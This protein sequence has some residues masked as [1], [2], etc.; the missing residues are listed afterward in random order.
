MRRRLAE[1]ERL[2]VLPAGRVTLRPLEAS[3]AEELYQVFSDPV[4][5]RYWSSP[6]HGSIQ[7]TREMIASIGDGFEARTIFQWGVER[8]DDPRLLGTVTLMP[9]LSQPRAEIG[10]I[11][12]REYWGLGYAGEAQR[13]A[14]EFG[15]DELALHR[16]EADT[17]PE[18]ERSARSLER[19]GFQPEGL[20]RERWVVDGVLS[21]SQIWGLLA[22]ERRQGSAG[23]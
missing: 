1:V 5:M 21:D 18:N 10:F 4:T 14:I 7:R 11:I 16:I 22:S 15:F 13:T 9:H 12:G 2:P 6:P 19:L 17:H 23:R 8:N 20:L 3:D